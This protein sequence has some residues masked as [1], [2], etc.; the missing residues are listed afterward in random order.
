M[1]FLQTKFSHLDMVGRPVVV[2]EKENAVPEHNQPFQVVS[3]LLLY[4]AYLLQLLTCMQENTF[5]EM[6][7]TMKKL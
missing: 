4:A 5:E 2:L 1:G 6:L 3:L 7:A